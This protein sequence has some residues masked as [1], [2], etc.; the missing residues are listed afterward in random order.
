MYGSSPSPQE[1]LIEIFRLR[2]GEKKNFLIRSAAVCSIETHWAT[3]TRLCAGDGCRWCSGGF[4][5]SWRGYV[6]AIDNQRRAGLIEITAGS[7]DEWQNALAAGDLHFKIISVSRATRW[8]AVRPHIE[9][10]QDGPTWPLLTAAEIFDNLCR[11]LRLPRRKAFDAEQTW[12]DAVKAFTL[13]QGPE[14]GLKAF[15]G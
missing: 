3:G 1:P 14:I 4:E 9:T 6:A 12:L 2:P 10:A 15:A 7:F 13:S 11:I 8:A 5:R